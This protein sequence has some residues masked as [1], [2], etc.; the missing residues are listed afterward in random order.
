MMAQPDIERG[1]LVPVLK[2]YMPTD[3]WL[4]AAYTQ[5]RHNSAALRAM[6]DFLE[7]KVGTPPVTRP[8]KRGAGGARAASAAQA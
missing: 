8:S 3:L 4:Y 5:R 1:A 7:S 6:L 2:E